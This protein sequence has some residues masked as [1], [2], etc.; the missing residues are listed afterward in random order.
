MVVNGLDRKVFSVLVICIPLIPY[1]LSEM[2]GF[3]QCVR[4]SSSSG[5]VIGNAR[6]RVTLWNLLGIDSKP[7]RD[8]QWPFT[9]WSSEGSIISA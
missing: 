2:S 6:M 5:I 8:M 7:R 1:V 3:P 9:K 4:I